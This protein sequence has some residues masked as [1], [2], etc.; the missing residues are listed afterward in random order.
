MYIIIG[1]DGKEYG[2]ITGEDLRRWIAE[3]RLNA[4]S[5][6]KAESDAQF[7]TLATFPE[8]SHLF[9]IAPPVPGVAPLLVPA[10][11]GR[12]AALDKIKVP[13]I[14]LII[15]S[16]ISF[17]TSLY[18]L[19]TIKQ[20]AAQMQE[21]DSIMAQLNNPQLQQFID[22]FTRFMSGPFGVANYLFQLLI[23]VLIFIGAL[24]MIKLRSYE[25]SYA[26]A[27]L[28]VLPCIQP[29]CGWILGLIFGIWAMMALGKI[30]PHFS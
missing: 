6:A 7:R 30:K 25:L 12:Q 10:D 13:A 29:C 19:A 15:S 16:V 26:A 4:Q 17:L 5:L 9:G 22:S 18:G 2:P 24:K 27:I 21:F 11:G 23:A 3:G 8:F 20:M 1:G 28:A 14:G